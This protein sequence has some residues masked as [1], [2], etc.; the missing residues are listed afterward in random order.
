VESIL[1]AAGELIGVRLCD[2]VDLG[3]SGRSTVLR[4]RADGNGGQGSIVVKA[5]TGGPDTRRGFAAE[6]AG[7][8]LGLAG[9]RLLGVDPRFPLVVMADLG[10]APTLADVLLGDDPKAAAAGLREWARALGCLAAESVHRRAGLD[11]LWARY[12]EGL[13][14]RGDEPW[15]AEAAD[16]LLT[17]L[18]ETG[19]APPPGLDEELARIERALRDAYPAFTPGDTCLDNSLVTPDGLRL[20]DFESACFSSVFLT[21]VYARMPF[22]SC[23]CVFRLPSGLAAEAEE[24]YRAQAAVAYPALAEEAVWQTGMRQAVAAWTGHLTGALLPRA[25]PDGPMHTTRRPIATR[26][27]ILRHRWETASRLTEFPA[28]AETMRLLLARVAVT[29]DAPALPLYPAFR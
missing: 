20:L 17:R 11:R 19:I 4:C 7:L 13:T 21:A 26:R 15:I 5:Y 18:T 25:T 22:P 3:G 1:R 6:A 9:P 23:W 12:G 8:S 29:W 28:L 2:P 14:S 10:A 24:I 27:Q 16:R